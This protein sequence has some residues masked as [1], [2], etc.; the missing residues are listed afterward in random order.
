M[1]TGY[2]QGK[3]PPACT[4]DDCCQNRLDMLKS[5]KYKKYPQPKMAKIK[6]PKI[7]RIRRGN[8]SYML[9]RGLKRVAGFILFIVGIVGFI[10]YGVATICCLDLQL[11]DKIISWMTTISPEMADYYTNIIWQSVWGGDTYIPIV[12]LLISAGMI[13]LGYRLLTR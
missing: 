9:A 4:C 8:L 13:W 3:H 2:I 12:L 6:S 5:G 1:K 11:A 7:K 10:N